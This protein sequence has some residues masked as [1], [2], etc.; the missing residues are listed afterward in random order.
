LAVLGRPVPDDTALPM[1]P[2]DDVYFID[3]EPAA[4]KRPGAQPPRRPKIPL[5]GR[6][7]GGDATL[8]AE[9]TVTQRGARRPM[10]AASLSLVLCGAGQL[11]NGRRDLALLYLLTEAL[12][13]SLDWFLWRLWEPLVRLARIFDILPTDLMAVA[14]IGNLLFVMF[15]AAN[16]QQ[17][18][19]DATGGAGAES[20]R[21]PVLSSLASLVMP[22]WGQILNAQPRKGLVLMVLFLSSAYAFGVSLALPALWRLL[23]SS[24]QM[25]FGFTLTNGGLMALS[26]AVVV[27]LSAFYDA[28]LVGRRQRSQ[29]F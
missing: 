16:A 10:V 23:D 5:F 25:I 29:A 26:A 21:Q 20:L 6:R 7:R 27:Y 1:S 24:Y 28:W 15:V 12:T 22:G 14:A 18:Y 3:A 17:A 8:A 19:R 9:P 4:A 13:A 2:Q 11:Y